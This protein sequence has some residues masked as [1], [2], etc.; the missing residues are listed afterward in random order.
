M[1]LDFTPRT[2]GNRLALALLVAVAAVLAVPAGAGAKAK[3]KP[4]KVNVMTRNLYL[5]ADLTPGVQA[6]S[7]QG[8]VDAAG[9]ILKQVDDN[10]FTVR[11]KG[12]AAEI[13]GKNPDLVG[14]QEVALWRTEPCTESPLPPHATQVR[15]D[16]LQLLL[17]QLNKGKNRYRVV[18]AQPEFDF[19]I[20]VNT[21]GNEST[22]AAGCPLGSE[23]NARLTMRDVILARNGRVQTSNA[24]GANFG[25]LLQVKPGGVATNVTRGWTR[26]DAKVRGAAKFRFVDTHLEAFDNQASNHASTGSDVGNGAIREAQAKELTKS[27]GPATGTRPVILVGDLNSD[28]KTEVKPGDGLAYRALL[29]AGFAE[30]STSRPLGCCLNASLITTA[31]G[32][33]ASDFDHKVDHVM[34]NAPKKLKLV[35][36][37][38]TGR[39]PVNGFWD[40]DHAGLFSTLSLP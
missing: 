36:S 8:L 25:T 19:E 40:S 30:R 24:K 18:I 15:Y 23:L 37:S 1:A 3:P 9:V 2:S 16:F 22:A 28:T 34:T 20:W 6:T 39:K 27:G 31:G 7:L 26:V 35:S 32:G 5:G 12:L 11:A 13:V 10:N 33:K 4:A 14:L 38:V 21:D 17:K 29:K